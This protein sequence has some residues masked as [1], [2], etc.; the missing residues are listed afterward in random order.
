M[1][2]MPKQC[3]SFPRPSLPIGKYS[4]INLILNKII[5]LTPNTTLEYILIVMFRLECLIER[6]SNNRF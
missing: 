4:S 6:I 3:M 1:I 2:L 5:N